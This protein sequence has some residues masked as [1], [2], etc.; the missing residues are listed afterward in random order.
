MAGGARCVG[1]SVEWNIWVKGLG[2]RICLAVPGA[3][4]AVLGKLI[5]SG[6]CSHSAARIAELNQSSGGTAGRGVMKG[7][8]RCVNRGRKQV[9]RAPIFLRSVWAVIA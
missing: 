2:F 4:A 8:S 9:Q 5:A 7:L 1:T 3:C 6:F